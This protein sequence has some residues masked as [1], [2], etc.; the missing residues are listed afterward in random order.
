MRR[1]PTHL[2]QAYLDGE[3]PEPVRACIASHLE[4]CSH[5]RAELERLAAEDRRLSA[6]FSLPLPAPRDV[7]AATLCRLGEPRHGN[8]IR[9]VGLV[10]A[11]GAVAAVAVVVLILRL[12]RTPAPPPS[13]QWCSVLSVTGAPRVRAP[14]SHTWGRLTHSRGILPGDAI[15]TSDV[16][17]IQIG[18]ANGTIV[19]VG[20]GS[21]AKVEP[22]MRG[23][24]EIAVELGSV[25]VKLRPK[26]VPL[27]V[28]TPYATA[29]AVGTDFEVSVSPER[30]TQVDVHRGVVRLSAAGE[31]VLVRGGFSTEA[32]PGRAPGPPRRIEYMV[33]TLEGSRSVVRWVSA[34]AD[35]RVFLARMLVGR[36]NCGLLW[37]DLLPGEW[38]EMRE[39]GIFVTRVRRGSPADRAG[40]RAGDV[41]L[42]LGA[43]PVRDSR[44][45]RAL[46]SAAD[47]WKPLTVTIARGARR[48]E[49]VLPEDDRFGAPEKVP[50]GVRQA[51]ASAL[52]GDYA[53]AESAYRALLS[54]YPRCAN[55]HNNLAAVLERRGDLPG[56]LQHYLR[57][58]ALNPSSALYRYNAAAV[59]ASAGN[60]KRAEQEYASASKLSA[61]WASPALGRARG[62]LLLGRLAEARASVAVAEERAH[63]D[64]EVEL[65]RAELLWVG[66]SV[67]EALA[68]ARRAAEGGAPEARLLEGIL[69]IS[70]GN[71][72]AAA[73]ALQDGLRRSPNDPD[74][75]D[76][77]ALA[78]HRGGRSAEAIGAYRTALS[79]A[80]ERTGIRANMA[81]VLLSMG[82]IREALVEARTAAL[83]E[84]RLG[85]SDGPGQQA[86][87]ALLLRCARMEEAED[88]LRRL[89]NLDADSI[90]AC[91]AMHLLMLRRGDRRA[92]QSFWSEAVALNWAEA[93]RL[94]RRLSALEAPT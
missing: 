23:P 93:V 85:Q 57:A 60:I 90:S 54:S 29:V 40:I 41:V 18:F 33:T 19:A 11:V 43:H 1:H 83:L 75:L 28:R 52:R 67:R 89:R 42:T 71:Y 72:G 55:L 9:R 77:L 80:P 53:G 59:L 6:Y 2:L 34:E 84:A 68:S 87:S 47:P 56:A 61:W 94:K 7:V 88:Q 26:G 15:R 58:A 8:Q 35:R 81:K 36:L 21:M 37:R 10:L 49:T 38:L 39:G 13:P 78:Y 25:R 4:A 70:L 91:V 27:A 76:A 44:D 62:L 24:V 74:L 22:G 63:G 16:D 50:S 69:L 3:L 45:A 30:R 31:A 32:Y 20:Y 46:L 82:R 66:G 14:G 64:P 48:I 12:H 79:T 86:Y 5:C 51:D 73:K 92:A 17:A 65:A